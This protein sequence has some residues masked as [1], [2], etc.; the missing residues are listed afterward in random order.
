MNAIPPTACIAQPVVIQLMQPFGLSARANHVPSSA[1]TMRRH[2]RVPRACGAGIIVFTTGNGSGSSGPFLLNGPEQG[3]M[4]VPHGHAP[5]VELQ[6][7][8]MRVTRRHA[9]F[10]ELKLLLRL[11]LLP[12]RA[13]LRVL[14]LRDRQQAHCPTPR[15]PI[16][17][18]IPPSMPRRTQG[19]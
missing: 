1:F 10:V 15:K 14:V 5:F 4:R 13:Q 18:K 17:F 19:T 16:V 6:P 3:P 12:R 8:P 11:H 9:P 2:A 7:G